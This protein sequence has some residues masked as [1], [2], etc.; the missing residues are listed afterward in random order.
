[1]S[2]KRDTAGAARRGERRSRPAGRDD[3]LRAAREVALEGGWK[4]V[5]VRRIAERIGYTNPI[6][7]EHF[8]SKD[9]VLVELLRQGFAELLEGIEAARGKAADPEEA[10]VGM[11][12]AY[13]G[14][15]RTAPDLYQV[16]YGLGGV[17]FGVSETWREG[18][19][20]GH[21]IGAA[22]EEILQGYGRDPGDAQDPVLMLWGQVHGLVALAMAGRLEGGYDQADRLTERSVRDALVAWREGQG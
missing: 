4:A 3:I 13:V 22:V 5:T 7:Y 1:M 16:M 9:D 11:A 8:G 12:H 20:I 17:P 19:E 6:V 18:W 10:L 14:F 21:A 15:A 2:A